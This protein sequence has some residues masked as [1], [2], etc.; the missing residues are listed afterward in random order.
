MAIVCTVDAEDFRF[1]VNSLILAW[2]FAI[3]SSSV[4]GPVVDFDSSSSSSSFSSS[5]DSSFE[6]F[7][8]SS[9]EAFSSSSLSSALE[10]GRFPEILALLAASPAF[11]FFALGCFAGFFRVSIV[12]GF[13]DSSYGNK[14][15]CF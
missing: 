1:F 11:A 6:C 3:S 13:L 12:I 15:D 9:S 4:S 7:P 8:D 14:I 2:S 5:D 10:D